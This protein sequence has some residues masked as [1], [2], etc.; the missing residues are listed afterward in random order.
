MSDAPPRSFRSLRA[1]QRIHVRLT[2]LYGLAVL[3]V[4][5]PLTALVYTLAV[6]GENGN[7]RTFIEGLVVTYAAAVDG[8]RLEALTAT[9]P[10]HAELETRARSIIG[11]TEGV[12]TIYILAPSD[13]PE[14]MRFLLDTDTR[15]TPAAFG[16]LYDIRRYAALSSG[17]SRP[18]VE[19]EPVAD[20]WGVSISG[21]A[22]VR[23]R[24]GAIVAV[25]GVDVDAARVDAIK[26]DMLLVASVSL[27]AALV[28]LAL[29]GVGVGRMLR[30]P[31]ARIIRGTEAIAEGHLGARVGVT[32]GDEFGV[33][34]G[35]FDRMAEGLEERD[36]IRAMFGRYVSEDVARRLIEERRTGLIAGEER[37]V[38]ILFS[39]IRSYT[40][41][42]ERLGPQLVLGLMNQYIEAMNAVVA[43]AGGCVLEYLGD[44]ILAVFGAPEDLDGHE[45]RAVQAAVAM[46][47]AL[48]RLNGRWEADGTAVA[49][50][51]QGIA[52]LAARIGLH[53]GSVVAGSI[54]SEI[55]M[56]YTI[57]GDSV[58]VASRIEGLNRGL[59]TDVLLSEE[60]WRG[61]P[62]TL[63]AACVDHGPQAV[64]GRAEPVRVFSPPRHVEGE[65]SVSA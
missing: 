35:H 17:V 44:G 25:V 51:G 5:T 50:Q 40:T 48:E 10:Y 2:G 7:L 14:R 15:A 47:A 19:A 18:V 11:A 37:R 12:A 53:T 61:L 49:W 32:R 55:R 23:N 42:S 56:K 22:P 1:W 20:K 62:E 33:L 13:V 31:M 52:R 9:D 26:A 58:N 45:A 64:K 59:G 43:D 41:I 38:T 3:M 29:A 46:Q 39:D 30:N 54:G 63:R 21:F 28:L 36:F 8:D 65:P 6:R 4:L 34:G 60:T 24:A 57:M 16:D 27:G